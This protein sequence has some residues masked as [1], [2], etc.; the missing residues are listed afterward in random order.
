MMKNKKYSEKEM[1]DLKVI[2]TLSRCFQSVRRAEEVWIKEKGVTL[3]QFGVIELLYHKGEMNVREIIKKTLSTAG[4]MTVVID[5]LAKEGYVK[6]YKNPEDKREY[7]V[8]ISEKGRE[9]MENFFPEHIENLSGI[10]KALDSKEKE[11]MIKL[12]KK[13]GK[14]IDKI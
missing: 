5:N 11:K 14:S 4:N 7:I 6:K 13:L 10:L 1:I 2:I 3:A 12:C 9:F 8:E